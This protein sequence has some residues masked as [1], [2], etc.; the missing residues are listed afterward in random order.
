[1]ADNI[2]S[3]VVNATKWSA[4]AE[5]TAKLI[6]PITSMVLARVLTPEAFGV[7]ATITMITAFADIFTEAG[8]QRYV[9]QHEFADDDDFDKS[10]NV[11]FWA[12]FVLSGILWAVIIIFAD[13]LATLVGNPRLGNVLI[14]A[15]ISIPLNA[16]SSIQMAVFKRAL[17]FKSLFFRRLV[18]VLIPLV[19]TIPLALWL[20]SY[21]ALIFGTIAVNLS[22]AIILTLQSP[23][24]P[25]LYFCWDRLKAMISYS[26]WAM[27]DAVL[28]WATNYLE[29]FF[30][31]VSL[32]AYYIGV[33]KTA[34]STVGHFTSIITAA[35]LPVVMP[36]FSRIQN[37]HAAM[38]TMLLKM[39]KY[40]AVLLFP[41]GFGIFIFRDMITWIL[42]GRQW[43]DAIMF[44]GIWAI[45]DVVTVVL[46]RFCS[47]IY[48]AIG[49]PR[50]SV[51]VQILHL[52]FLIPAVM[53]SVNY[54]FE[55][56][57]WTRTLVRAQ[58]IFVNIVFAYICIKQ[59][60][61][62]ML[63]NITPELLACMVM[64]LTGYALLSISSNMIISCVWIAVCSIVYF[65]FLSLFKDDRAILISIKG[66]YLDK[67]LK[68]CKR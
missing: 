20:R 42:L 18:A 10:T 40:M 11:A 19:I 8:F 55:A 67:I 65:A 36:A 7:V 47:N 9:I 37:D 56:L 38:R 3:K 66:K 48:P 25:R 26:M 5:V 60:P 52:I 63:L 34:T 44:M 12:N 17:D 28:I 16:F 1:M 57:Y 21:W 29:I 41:L 53:L 27:V 14:V 15:C 22:N 33:Y 68:K 58:L 50:L 30:I 45:A 54:G 4:L 2:N 35:V 59:S 13:P 46:S 51:V 43:G 49:K 6:A 61:L 39:Q 23:W 64:T 31:S 24:K 62:K 32:S